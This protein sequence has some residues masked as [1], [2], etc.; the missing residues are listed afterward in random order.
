M[1]H[2]D[3]E[4]N[5]IICWK[6]TSLRFK[7]K[8][9][10]WC[11][12]L[13]RWKL[14]YKILFKVKDEFYMMIPS[15]ELIDIWIPNWCDNFYEK[16]YDKK[17]I[18]FSGFLDKPSN[19]YKIKDLAKNSIKFYN[20][21][22]SDYI[23]KIHAPNMYYIIH[24]LSTML[25]EQNDYPWDTWKYEKRLYRFLFC[26]IIIVCATLELNEL[27]KHM[28]NMLELLEH[29]KFFIMVIKEKITESNKNAI[30]TMRNL[31]IK[32]FTKNDMIN[33]IIL[34]ILRPISII[35]DNFYKTD[36]YDDVNNIWKN[37]KEYILL[38]NNFFK[39]IINYMSKKNPMLDIQHYLGGKKKIL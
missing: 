16:E 23:K 13:V 24:D 32:A 17:N 4:N 21:D 36:K 1:L 25:Y 19:Y 29:I 27:K 33:F 34:S 31:F 20:D 11:F 15:G 7:N 14:K 37:V 28:E 12:N 6:N 30:E 8:N 35:T 22:Y 38:I 9:Y 2:L 18:Y 10:N 39:N 5:Y 26:Y 3:N